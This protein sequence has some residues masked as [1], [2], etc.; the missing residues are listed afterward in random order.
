MELNYSVIDELLKFSSRVLT[1][2]EGVKEDKINE[3][4]KNHNLVLSND[5]KILL[6]RTNGLDLMGSTVYGIYD[7]SVILS[8]DGVFKFEHN[9]VEN[10][11]PDNLIPFSPDGRG[12]HYCFDSAKCDASAEGTITS[13]HRAAGQIKKEVGV[14]V[15]KKS[16]EVVTGKVEINKSGAKAPA[17]YVG[18]EHKIT[19]SSGGGADEM[20]G[21]TYT[22][23]T[24][25]QVQKDGS[26]EVVATSKEA[27]AEVFCFGS[28]V[29]WNGAA[30]QD[31]EIDKVK[32]TTTTTNTAKSSVGFGFTVGAGLVL[33]IN[34]QLG[35]KLSV[36]KEKDN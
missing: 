14:D 12:N 1:L 9:E 13:G 30:S 23:K 4:E 34:I 32:G 28:P 25:T 5:C 7:E 31:V 20:V 16:T 29:S 3:F 10:E 22:Q 36:K 27:A 2:N 21:A 6:R 19:T 35:I 15:N 17:D 11:M 24:T 26:E 33:D 8:L 18:R